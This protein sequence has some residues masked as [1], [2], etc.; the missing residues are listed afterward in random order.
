MPQV[1]EPH[2]LSGVIQL[3]DR[4]I[5]IAV[6]VLIG[7]IVATAAVGFFMIVGA[8]GGL[9]A[10][11][12]PHS[13]SWASGAYA[14]PVAVALGATALIAGQILRLLD[15]GRPHGPADLIEAAQADRAPDLRAGAISSLLALNNLA[16]GASVGIFGPLVHLGGC[17]A[18]AVQTRRARMPI[19]LVLGCGAGAAIAA[20]FSAPFGAT[21]FAHEA[22]MRRFSAFGAAP[23][24][25]ACFV[26]FWVS[27]MMLGRHRFFDVAMPPTLDLATLMAVMALG[28][29]CGVIATLYIHAVTAMPRLVRATGIPLA[30]RPLVPAAVLFAL[31]PVLPHLLGSGV[32]SIELA[33][34][35]QL[36]VGL[37]VVL[38]AGKLF[39]TALC[40]GFGYFG[41]VF[42]PALFFGAMLGAIAD[43]LLGSGGQMSFALVGAA[44]AV[45]AVIGAPVAAIVIV[46]EMTGSYEGAVL[47]M[48]STVIAA[49]ISRSF[50]GRSLFDRQL[51]MRGITVMDD[52]R[53]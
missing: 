28:L 19:D 46:F 4:A 1:P 27:E 23:V 30:W 34:A 32:G 35:G 11:P 18:A 22:I 2:P 7:A 13:I 16:G 38:I 43:A 15:G 52:H 6:A 3:R 33:I 17:L 40:L 37:L 31:S 41:G 53:Q 8:V 24:L 10:Q 51:A 21:I 47:S 49:Q 44:S 14:V 42:A 29:A 5:A 39:V 36:G 9:W 48:I 25:G 50:A 45:A 26:A 12:L 20:V